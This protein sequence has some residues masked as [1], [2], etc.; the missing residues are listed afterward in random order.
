MSLCAL[1]INLEQQRNISDEQGIKNQTHDLF[2]KKIGYEAPHFVK[3]DQSQVKRILMS[4]K[5]DHIQITE[6]LVKNF[7]NDKLEESKK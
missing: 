3:F 5:G 6:N 7:E 4:G 1:N 2:G